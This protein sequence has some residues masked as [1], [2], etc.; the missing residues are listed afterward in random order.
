M[1]DQDEKTI[2]AMNLVAFGFL[3]TALGA[4]VLSL[5]LFGA[6]ILL[7]RIGGGVLMIGAAVS[8]FGAFGHFR[9]R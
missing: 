8:L 4:V 6:A 2:T 1:N 5:G 7:A 9:S 3:V